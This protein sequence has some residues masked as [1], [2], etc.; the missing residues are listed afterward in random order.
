MTYQKYRFFVKRND[1]VLFL[2]NCIS[3]SVLVVVNNRVEARLVSLGIIDGDDVEIRSGL[4]EGD[5]VVLRS[6]PFLRD[7]EIVNAIRKD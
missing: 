4:K 5:Q 3:V 6:A 7:G 2:Q 1:F